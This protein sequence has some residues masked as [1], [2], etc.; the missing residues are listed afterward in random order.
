MV[1]QS[2]FLSSFNNPS[3]LLFSTCVRPAAVRLR[4]C[5]PLNEPPPLPHLSPSTMG[6]R[7]MDKGRRKELD[8]VKNNSK[9]DDDCE[10]GLSALRSFSPCLHC[11]MS[12][13]GVEIF[14]GG[15]VVVSKA[16]E[17]IMERPLLRTTMGEAI[18]IIVRAVV[19]PSS[20][21]SAPQYGA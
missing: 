19:L 3:L 9:D 18:L 5:P 17:G 6:Q 11:M 21:V 15:T 13:G 20:F 4:H 12:S 16:G 2:L 10:N 14:G 1:C 7:R 8:P